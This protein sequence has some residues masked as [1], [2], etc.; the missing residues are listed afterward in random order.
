MVP[1]VANILPRKPSRTSFGNSPLWS[2]W[3]CVRT[4]ASTSVGPERKGAVVELLQGFLALE[5]AAVDQETPGRRFDQIA[6]ARH[7]VRRAAKSNGHAHVGISGDVMPPISPRSAAARMSSSGM[8][9]VGC[10]TLDVERIERMPALAN[11]AAMSGGNKRVGDD[12]VDRRGA[13]RRERVGAGD[14]RA[15]GGDDVVDQQHRPA[16]DRRRVGKADFDGAIA[17]ANFL[18]HRMRKP[19]PAGEIAHPGSR[20]PRPG[21]P[22][23]PRDRCHPC[24]AHS[25][26]PAWPTGFRPRCRETP[27]VCRRCGAGAHPP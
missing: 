27:S 26:S 20:T 9:L 13:G 11:S 14:Q 19:E 12:G 15:A 23:W 4:T 16:G 5:Q 1:R 10:G 8:A 3:A 22:R 24:A 18:R 6:R 2:I 17:A 25:R 21:R 7:G